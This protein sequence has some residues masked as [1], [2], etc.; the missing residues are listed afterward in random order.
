MQLRAEYRSAEGANTLLWVTSLVNEGAQTMRVITWEDELDDEGILLRR[1]YRPLSLSW[2]EAAQTRALLEDTGF[3]VEACYGDF[4]GT[5]FDPATADE[6]VWV[7][8]K[9]RAS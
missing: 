6:Q 5:T 9:G 7:A 8:R 1:Q 4:A 3:T 2:M